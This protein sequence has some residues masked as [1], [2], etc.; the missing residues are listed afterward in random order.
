MMSCGFVTNYMVQPGL[1][2][3]SCDWIYAE[4]C[5]RLSGETTEQPSL[6]LLGEVEAQKSIQDS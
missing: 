3:P 2:T 1:W 5:L 4:P 6:C